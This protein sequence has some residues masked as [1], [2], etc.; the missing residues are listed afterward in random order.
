MS[1]EK[2]KVVVR[3]LLFI[4]SSLLIPYLLVDF[5]FLWYIYRMTH[6]AN[7]RHTATG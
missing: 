2:N 5:S 4:L 1:N 6:N 7:R 3:R